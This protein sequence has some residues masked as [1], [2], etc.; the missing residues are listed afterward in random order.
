M[1]HSKTTICNNFCQLTKA[2]WIYD[3]PH[4]TISKSSVVIVEVAVTFYTTH[5]SDVFAVQRSG[6]VPAGPLPKN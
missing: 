3:G 2:Y 5:N 1:Q 4:N 6:L